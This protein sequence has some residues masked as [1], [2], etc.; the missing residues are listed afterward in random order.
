MRLDR[1]SYKSYNFK[2]QAV[3]SSAYKGFSLSKL[4]EVFNYLQSTAFNFKLN[5]YPKMDKTVHS[6][7]KNG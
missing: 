3:E 2:N 5:N 4:A 7:R 1:T 6:C